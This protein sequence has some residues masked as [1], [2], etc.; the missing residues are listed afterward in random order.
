[1][2]KHQI[3]K[4]FIRFLFC[5]IIPSLAISAIFYA[6]ETIIF[7]YRLRDDWNSFRYASWKND[8]FGVLYI[9]FL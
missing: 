6:I 9:F 7:N 2:L 8:T 4:T 5:W 1:M 3:I